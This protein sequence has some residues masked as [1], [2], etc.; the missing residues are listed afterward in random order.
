MQYIKS[1]DILI[2][3]YMCTKLIKSYLHVGQPFVRQAPFRLYCGLKRMMACWKENAFKFWR[4]IQTS[5]TMD[6]QDTVMLDR[7][8]IIEVYKLI[9]YTMHF[10]W[11][12]N[13]SGCQCGDIA[14]IIHQNTMPVYVHKAQSHLYTEFRQ[15]RSDCFT[16]ACSCCVP[17]SNRVGQTLYNTARIKMYPTSLLKRNNLCDLV[18]GD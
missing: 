5:T 1:T 11:W 6:P 18:R 17:D 15:L 14:Q 4:M 8:S 10:H 16:V 2:L 9:L 13:K 7:R 12:Y 3:I